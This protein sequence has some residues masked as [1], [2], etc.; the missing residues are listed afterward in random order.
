MKK[1]KVYE[2]HT[3]YILMGLKFSALTTGI[4]KK[5]KSEEVE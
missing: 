2:L 1:R 5:K 3:G 4:H